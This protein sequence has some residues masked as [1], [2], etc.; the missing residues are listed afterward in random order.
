MLDSRSKYRIATL[1]LIGLFTTLMAIFLIN[2]AY[3]QKGKQVTDIPKRY[4]FVLDSVSYM[5]VDSILR[6]SLMNTG[7]ELKAKDADGLRQ[8]LGL[9]ISYFQR[10]RIRQDTIGMVKP[11]K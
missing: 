3:S 5:A 2:V 9:V 4:T 1:L 6:M 8:G 10:E 11:K 7:Y